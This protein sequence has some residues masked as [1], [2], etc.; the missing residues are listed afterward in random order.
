MQ[1]VLI[2]WSLELSQNTDPGRCL[3]VL[4]EKHALLGSLWNYSESLTAEPK[5]L[6]FSSSSRWFRCFLISNSIHRE[7]GGESYLV[8]LRVVPFCSRLQDLRDISK[9]DL[10][11]RILRKVRCDYNF[12]SRTAWVQIS[13]HMLHDLGQFSRPLCLRFL[14]CQSAG[15]SAYSTEYRKT[16]A[17]PILFSLQYLTLTEMIIF[18]FCFHLTNMY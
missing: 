16:V 9:A 3:V 13:T 8:Y 10:Q 11:T 6:H 4:G 1:K 2:L 5:N 15:D 17:S 7:K 12:Q 18:C 14:T